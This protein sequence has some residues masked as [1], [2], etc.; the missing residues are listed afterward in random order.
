M[1]PQP[2]VAE[3]LFGEDDATPMSTDRATIKP[4]SE[5]A[6]CL[7]A[8][9]KAWLSTVRPDGRPHA[10]PVSPVWLDGTP[11]FTTRPTSRKG[12]NLAHDDR[13]VL[14][15]A[16]DTLD[17]VV[18]GEARRVHGTGELRAAA[19]AF[20]T[21]YAWELTLRAGAAYDDSLPGSPEYAFYR[22]EPTRAYGFGPDGLT[23]TRW[24]VGRA[25]A[26]WSREG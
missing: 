13:C 15:A 5:A 24:L 20:R 7:G 25:G 19:E 12:R 17:L 14:T 26:G 11:W 16:S 10:M 9:P 22:L 23:A 1:E 8:A 2:V 6:A 21:K 4:W 18:E 3:L